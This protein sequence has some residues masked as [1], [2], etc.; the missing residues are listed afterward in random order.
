MIQKLK[1]DVKED[2][3][4]KLKALKENKNIVVRINIFQNYKTTWETIA[5]TTELR[6]NNNKVHERKYINKTKKRNYNN[7][8]TKQM[9]NNINEVEPVR[10]NDGAEQTINNKFY[11]HKSHM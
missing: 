4:N 1:I 9:R 2:N 10:N 5:T 3:S 11:I 7:N 6:S 8:E